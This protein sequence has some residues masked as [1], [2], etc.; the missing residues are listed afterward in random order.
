MVLVIK[1]DLSSSALADT[2]DAELTRILA[3]VPGKVARI[4]ERI[5]GCLCTADEADDQLRDINGNV[6]G[7]VRLFQPNDNPSEEYL[8][9]EERHILA[10]YKDD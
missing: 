7:S 6:V 5:P 10:S 2:C 3:G 1:L 4:K 8:N 9:E